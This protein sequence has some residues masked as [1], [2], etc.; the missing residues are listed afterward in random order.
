MVSFIYSPLF[1]TLLGRPSALIGSTKQAVSS[2]SNASEGYR[3][4]KGFGGLRIILK[5][6]GQQEHLLEWGGATSSYIPFSSPSSSK[7][8]ALSVM[9]IDFAMNGRMRGS[10]IFSQPDL[11]L[12]KEFGISLVMVVE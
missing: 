4:P 2:N 12:A 3:R 9:W 1:G 8:L 10:W 11:V 7:T 5:K 6:R